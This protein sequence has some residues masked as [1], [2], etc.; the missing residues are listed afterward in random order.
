MKDERIRGY[1]SNPPCGVGPVELFA[2]QCRTCYQYQ[3]RTGNPRPADIVRRNSP[4]VIER[5]MWKQVQQRV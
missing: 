2:G 4:R 1:C 3:Y 5:L